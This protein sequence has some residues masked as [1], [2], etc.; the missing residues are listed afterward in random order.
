MRTSKLDID[1]I[2]ISVASRIS[3]VDDSKGFEILLSSI[4]D[5]KNRLRISF[6]RSHAFRRIAEGD[7]LTTLSEFETPVALGY[8]VFESNFLNEF[9]NES[10]G[11]HENARH[12][13]FFTLD[14]VIDVIADEEP[15]IEFWVIPEE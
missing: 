12:F 2:S 15:K 14:D 11:V 5:K 3:I 10:C 13:I 4:K 7:F 9:H 8:E 1:Y 6:T